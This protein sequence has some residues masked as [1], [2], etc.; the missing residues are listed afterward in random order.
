MTI[1]LKTVNSAL[2]KS[3]APRRRHDPLLNI[4]LEQAE[5][6]LVTL[7]RHVERGE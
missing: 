2:R 4:G 7:H 5:C 6:C 1:L 3:A